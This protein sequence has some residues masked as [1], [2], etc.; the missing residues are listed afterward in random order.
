MSEGVKPRRPYR[1]ALR[2]E[3]AAR[4]R[5]QI[6]EAARSLFLERGFADATIAAIAERAG[7]APES[8]YS[9]YRTKA[10]LLDAVVRAAI[11]RND[12]PEDPL[13]RTWVKRLLGRPNLSARIIGYARHTAQTIELTSPL[14]A[15]IASAGTGDDELDELQRSLLDMRF[16]GQREIMAA[17]V[18]GESLRPGLTPERAADTFSA[19]ASPELHHLLTTRRGWSQ[20]RYARWLEAT[21]H[22]ALLSDIAPAA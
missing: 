4:T 7:V 1:S 16:S 21:I 18:Q 12:E 10:R 13:D 11:R 2:A 9:I 8:V 5:V 14:Y 20:Q 22:A 17:L 15:I 6:L 3:R 19:L